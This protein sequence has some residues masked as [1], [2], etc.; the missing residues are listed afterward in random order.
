MKCNV[1]R[2]SNCEFFFIILFQVLS[3]QQKKLILLPD[4]TV[5]INE[6]HKCAQIELSDN[7]QE[8]VYAVGLNSGKTL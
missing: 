4:V 7:L 2:G 3:N 6:G 8:M 5:L 1:D